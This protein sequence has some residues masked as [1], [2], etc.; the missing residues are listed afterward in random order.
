MLVHSTSC[1]DAQTSFQL[2]RDTFEAKYPNRC[3]TCDG[4]G[5]F[6]YREARPYGSTVAYEE[7]WEPCNNCQDQLKCSLCGAQGEEVEQEGLY[8]IIFTCGHTEDQGQKEYFPKT[9]EDYLGGPCPCDI[10]EYL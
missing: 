3:K 1:I 6:Q 2:R 8:K 5:G 9:W 7:F 4:T 10:A